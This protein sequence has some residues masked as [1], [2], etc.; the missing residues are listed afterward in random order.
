MDN[1]QSRGLQMRAI[2]ERL[3]LISQNKEDIELYFNRPRTLTIS[4]VDGCNAKCVMCPTHRR[5]RTWMSDQLFEK[6]LRDCRELRPIGITPQWQGEP[7]LDPKIL[8]RLELLDKTIPNVPM[9]IYTNASLLNKE[10]IKRLF[11][12]NIEFMNISINAAR[13]ESYQKVMRLNYRRLLENINLILKYRTNTRIQVSFVKVPDNEHEVDRFIETWKYSVDSIKMVD[14]TNW[15]GTMDTFDS[16]KKFKTRRNEMISQPG[17][18]LNLISHMYIL[19]NGQVAHC[20]EDM[21]G[22]FPIG[23]A[24]KKTLSELWHSKINENLRYKHLN[25]IHKRDIKLCKKC[26]YL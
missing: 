13:K 12:L 6:I 3:M 2:L 19:S 22:T 17:Q 7:F 5:K 9:V 25:G 15:G 18:C 8:S 23:D 14:A 20:C 11:E 4:T 10:K 26:N 24:N 16:N 1:P 21:G